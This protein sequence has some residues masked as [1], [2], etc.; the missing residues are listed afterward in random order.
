PRRAFG[1]ERIGPEPKCCE[2]SGAP[3]SLLRPLHPHPPVVAAPG[4]VQA[5][6]PSKPAFRCDLPLRRRNNCCIGA[7]PTAPPSVKRIR[8]LE[9]CAEPHSSSCFGLPARCRDPAATAPRS[10]RAATTRITIRAWKGYGTRVGATAHR[11]GVVAR[12]IGAVGA[13]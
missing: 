9:P 7:T 3:F 6:C 5:Q 2:R 11:V 13:F 1:E 8:L 10:R 4:L 12:I